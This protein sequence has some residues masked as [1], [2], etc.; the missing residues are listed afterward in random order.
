MLLLESVRVILRSLQR[1][2]V[3]FPGLLDEWLCVS[4]RPWPSKVLFAV[5]IPPLVVIT[6]TLAVHVDGHCFPLQRVGAVVALHHVLYHL[7]Y[8]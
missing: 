2:L 7:F 6:T 3:L 1:L 8:N 4:Q 5:W